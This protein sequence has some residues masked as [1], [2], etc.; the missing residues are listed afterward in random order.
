MITNKHTANLFLFYAV[1]ISHLLIT[2]LIVYHG[3]IVSM[4]IEDMFG[5]ILSQMPVFFAIIIN[6]IIHIKNHKPDDTKNSTPIN[7]H[8]VWLPLIFIIFH[9]CS[10]ALYLHLYNIEYLSN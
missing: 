8:M 3:E 6:L 10:I 7:K 1:I 5:L 9:V 4:N 2:I